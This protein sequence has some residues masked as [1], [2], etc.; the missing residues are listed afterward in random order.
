VLAPNR[1]PRRWPFAGEVL[2]LVDRIS[3]DRWIVATNG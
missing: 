2:N 3:I 1:F